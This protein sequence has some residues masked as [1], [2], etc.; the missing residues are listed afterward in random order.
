MTLKL[1]AESIFDTCNKKFLIELI[2]LIYYVIAMLKEITMGFQ[3]E[4]HQ[5]DKLKFWLGSCCS[6]F[7]I[8]CLMK[9]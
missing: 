9:H 4:L 1:L 8:F 6:I 5:I 7:Y 3:K 2:M